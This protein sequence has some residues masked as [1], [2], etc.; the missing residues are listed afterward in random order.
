MYRKHIFRTGGTEIAKQVVHGNTGST[1]TLIG[2]FTGSYSCAYFRYGSVPVFQSMWFPG[3][4]IPSTQKLQVFTGYQ[5][6]YQYRYATLSSSI[7]SLKL[8]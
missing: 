3:I 6:R 8:S 7:E 4:G 1:D 5:Y 2:V